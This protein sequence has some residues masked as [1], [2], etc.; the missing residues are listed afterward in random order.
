MFTNFDKKS[1][2]IFFTVLVWVLGHIGVSEA[3]VSDGE[4][5][6]KVDMCPMEHSFRGLGQIPK[7]IQGVM[8]F[9]SNPIKLSDS[10][11]MRDPKKKCRVTNIQLGSVGRYCSIC[12]QFKYPETKSQGEWNFEMGKRGMAFSL[13]S[14]IKIRKLK[15]DCSAF[16]QSKLMANLE[17]LISEV[18]VNP[19]LATNKI[20]RSGLEKCITT[21]KDKCQWLEFLSDQN[22]K[23]YCSEGQ[24][25]TVVFE[26]QSLENQKFN[27]MVNLELRCLSQKS[28]YY[29]EFRKG[30][31]VVRRDLTVEEAN[32]RPPSRDT[33]DSLGYGPSLEGL[34]PSVDGRPLAKFPCDEID[35]MKVESSPL[36]E[37]T[38][39]TNCCRPR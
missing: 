33:Y 2:F 38:S 22:K 31:S 4:S 16:D 19:R 9:S 27:E 7:G 24:I 15:I 26:L 36:I 29:R 32:S 3:R 35:V 25:R 17:T 21:Q 8:D 12:Y 18:N 1:T 11:L 28:L 14:A 34:A 20:E 6:P 23:K 30:S 37:R 5:V 13:H 10:I 39:E